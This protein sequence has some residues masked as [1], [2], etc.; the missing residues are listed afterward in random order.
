[1]PS[2]AEFR[3]LLMGAGLRAEQCELAE[4]FRAEVL[5]ENERQ[6]LTRLLLPADFFWGHV[7]DVLE[8]RQFRESLGLTGTKAVDLGTGAGVPGLLSAAL[9]PDE[10]WILVDSEVRKAEYLQRTVDLLGLSSR[11]RVLHGR[12]ER[13]PA[14]E[15]G[16]LVI[17][18]AV[19]TVEKIYSWLDECSTWNK[20][21]L[22]KGP[23]WPVEW[24]EFCQS[25]W[26]KC[27]TQQHRHEYSVGEDIRR[28]IIQLDRVPR[29]TSK[30]TPH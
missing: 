24:A 16:P 26:R 5:L 10:Q 17:S 3:E 14:N 15:L 25:R 22:L 7:V 27:L 12:I 2:D 19:G 20:L 8:L 9:F 6:N 29:G 21:M 1:M 23:K 11:V 30:M 13:L 4:R 18:R 28:V